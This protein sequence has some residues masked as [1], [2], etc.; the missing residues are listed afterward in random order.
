MRN[1]MSRR[2]QRWWRVK[3]HPIF[4]CLM[5]LLTLAYLI[6]FE[7]VLVDV[8]EV[9]FLRNVSS[10]SHDDDKNRP[11]NGIDW[12]RNLNNLSLFV[13]P[14]STTAIISPRYNDTIVGQIR[15]RE[16]ACFVISSPNNA[17]Q[18]SVIRRTWGKSIKP[19]FLL[20]LTRTDGSVSVDE[21]HATM[22]AIQNEAQLFNDIIVEDFIDSYQNLTIKTAFALKHFVTHFRDTTFFFKIDDDVAMNVDRLIEFLNSNEVTGNE[23]IGMKGTSLLPHR[24]RESKW[25]IPY[26]MYNEDKFPDYLDGPAY[27]IPG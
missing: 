13:R 4:W 1:N 19:L 7:F 12:L 20:G 27:L 26:W 2:R 16:I 11:G 18:R 22:S 24:E 8:K 9:E 14:H 3:S 21:S 17:L 6:L 15:R 25:Y 23:I 10:V 5:G